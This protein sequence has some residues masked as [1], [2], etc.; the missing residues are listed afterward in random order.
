M[1]VILKYEIFYYNDPK[2]NDIKFYSHFIILLVLFVL[3][4][5]NNKKYFVAKLILFAPFILFAILMNGKRNIVFIFFAGLI[6]LFLTKKIFK[7]K[8]TYFIFIPLLLAML[9]SYSSFYQNHFNRVA[10][11]SFVERYTSYRINYGRDDTMKMVI[12]S[13]I[14]SDKMQILECRGQSAA[15]YP[16]FFIKR[17]VWPDKPYPYAVYFT[18]AMI[19]YDDVRLLGWGMTTSI[20]D[21]LFSNFGFVGIII[22]PYF[23]VFL[24]RLGMSYNKGLMGGVINSLS[25]LLSMLTIAVQITA[26]LSLYI[27]L[28]MSVIIYKLK[29]VKRRI[30]IGL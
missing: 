26:F 1:D 12:Y 22:S 24:C 23:V 3:V 20:F 11:E 2:F 5:E 17:E 6:Y 29:P 21:E 4:I 8:I 10:G 27:L 7:R 14:Y 30:K 25:I 13:E 18:N 15:F 28:F 16:L 9:F 19:G